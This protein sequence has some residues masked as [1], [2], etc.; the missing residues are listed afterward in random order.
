MN[1]KWLNANSKKCPKCKAP[2]EKIGGCNWMTCLT[3]TH[4]FCWLCLGDKS[5]HPGMSGPHPAQ[6]NNVEEVKRKGREAFMN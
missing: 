1:A 5:D 6:C 2:C 4:G 3:C